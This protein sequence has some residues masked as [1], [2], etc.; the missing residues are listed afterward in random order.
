MVMIFLSIPRW[1]FETLLFGEPLPM[2]AKAIDV[3]EQAAERD[4]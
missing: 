1:L 4:R 3:V 2:Q